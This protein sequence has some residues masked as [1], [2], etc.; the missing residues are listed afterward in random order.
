[1]AG[2]HV[3]EQWQSP[4][5]KTNFYHIKSAVDA[6]IKR[7]NIVGLQTI[8]EEGTYF[9]YGLNYMKGQKTLVSFG[10]VSPERLKKADVDGKVYFANFDWDLMLKVIAKNTIR[11]KE[12]PKF[13][14]VRRDLALLVDE[15]VT[16]DQLRL[17]A[18]KSEKKLLKEVNIFDVYKGDK[19]PEGKKS[20]ALSFI[21]QDEEKTLND[22]QIEGIIKKLMLNFEKEIGASVR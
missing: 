14:S 3:D 15:S 17:I 18:I 7:L 1:L 8:E 19:L 21:I 12:V 22:K 16:F 11:F 4:E 5:K 2:N 9:E 10:S 13:P 20:Y 6:I